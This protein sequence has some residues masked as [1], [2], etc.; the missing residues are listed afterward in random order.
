[1]L[2]KER[3]I[4]IALP[5]LLKHGVTRAG[6]FGSFADGTATEKSDIDL[7]VEPNADWSLLELIG[8]KLALE[9][10]L[11]RDV[12]LV[13]YRGIKSVIRDRVMGQELRFHG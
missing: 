7:L 2:T 8:L 11:H 12:D 3:I 10:A 1:M 9:D 13:D 4:E 5:V 6:L